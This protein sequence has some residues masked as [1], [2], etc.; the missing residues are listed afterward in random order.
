MDYQYEPYLRGALRRQ[1]ERT[2]REHKMVVG[3]TLAVVAVLFIV[4]LAA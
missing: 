1:G 2:E 3:W 4:V